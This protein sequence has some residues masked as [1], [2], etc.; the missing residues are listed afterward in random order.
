MIYDLYGPIDF[1]FIDAFHEKK[2]V[3]KDFDNFSKFVREGTGIIFMHDT[4]PSDEK[5]CGSGYCYTAW[6]AAWHIRKNYSEN[7]EIVTIP[8]PTTGLSILRKSSKQ[9]AWRNK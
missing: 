7:F 8:F 6:Q 9:L 4:H 5:H 2:Q 1:L 3:L